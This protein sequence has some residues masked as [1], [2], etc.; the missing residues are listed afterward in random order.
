[1]RYP[2]VEIIGVSAVETSFRNIRRVAFPASLVLSSRRS[3][4]DT[5]FG[6]VLLPDT[7]LRVH[8]S[9]IIAIDKIVSFRSG[10]VYIKDRHIPISESFT[11]AFNRNVIEKRLG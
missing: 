7:F 10:K 9:Y 6:Q 5:A 2:T 11:E 8:R 3:L 1:M 4:C